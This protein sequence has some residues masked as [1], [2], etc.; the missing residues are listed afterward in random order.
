MRVKKRMMEC[1]KQ[2]KPRFFEDQTM[3]MAM[4]YA[5]KRDEVRR[6]IERKARRHP[7]VVV[8]NKHSTKR[9]EAMVMRLICM[10]RQRKPSYYPVRIAPYTAFAPIRGKE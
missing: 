3:Q 8:M 6:E 4:R 10:I 2:Y 5:Q 7:V 1:Q 9:M